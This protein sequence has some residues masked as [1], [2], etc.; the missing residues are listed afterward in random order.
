MEIWTYIEILYLIVLKIVTKYL[1]IFCAR[2]SLDYILQ[3]SNIC[4]INIDAIAECLIVNDDSINRH[5]KQLK[6]IFNKIFHQ[7]F[8]CSI[9]SL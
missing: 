4:P 5:T 6:K 3:F 1:A 9:I 2:Q 7:I 8:N